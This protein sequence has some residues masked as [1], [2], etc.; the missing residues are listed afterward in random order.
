MSL[1]PDR[2]ELRSLNRSESGNFALKSAL[3]ILTS[4]SMFLTWK[5]IINIGKCYLSGLHK[6]LVHPNSIFIRSVTTRFLTTVTRNRDREKE[7]F[8]KE[9]DINPNI[10]FKPHMVKYE[11]QYTTQ[12]NN[13]ALCFLNVSREISW[14]IR[15][16]SG[17]VGNPWDAA[18]RARITLHFYSLLSNDQL[19]NCLVNNM[20]KVHFP[21]VPR[22][23]DV[24][25]SFFLGF[26]MKGGTALLSLSSRP[27][28]VQWHPA[29]QLFWTRYV[30]LGESK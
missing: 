20:T 3:T 28:A 2:T 18:S 4:I 1:F 10:R 14:K 29:C 12:D 26:L 30:G 13:N 8:F 6:Y 15:R 19:R 22:P 23:S 17:Q 25:I 24:A 21:S 27:I 5:H 11:F 16:N 7:T 9:C